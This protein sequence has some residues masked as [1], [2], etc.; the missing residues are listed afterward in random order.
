M[1]E[2]GRRK[3]EGGRRKVGRKGGRRK[4]EGHTLAICSSRGF[5]HMPAK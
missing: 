4:E 5:K 2:G 3:E 1:V